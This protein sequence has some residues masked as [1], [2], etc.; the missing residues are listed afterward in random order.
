MSEFAEPVR[1]RQFFISDGRP[2]YGVI[3]RW[4]SADAPVIVYCHG[5]AQEQLFNWRAEVLGADILAR[6]GY[7]TFSYHARAHGDSAGEFAELDFDGLVDD[8]MAAADRAIAETGATRIVWVGIRFGALVAATAIQRRNDTAALALW[9]PVH[10]ARDY[11]RM[12]MRRVLFFEVS[13]GRRPPLTA[14]QMV[15]ELNHGRAVSL[16]GFDL[17]PKFYASAVLAN[18]ARALEGWSRPTLLAQI[19]RRSSLAMEHHALQAMLERQGA[20]VTTI[21]F[22]EEPVWDNGFESWGTL[23]NLSRRMGDWL[24][25]LV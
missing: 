14:E 19:Q 2:L 1:H 15:D 23:D 20:T 9:E 18:L 6:R 8:A 10:N 21:Q 12:L 3:R 4:A 17:H 16:L 13:R 24:D 11:F 7:S 5:L 25:G 22:D